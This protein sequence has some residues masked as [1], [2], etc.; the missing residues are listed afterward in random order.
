M[1]GQRH[2]IARL[3]SDL[4][5]DAFRKTLR[6]LVIS[7]FIMFALIAAIIYLIFFQPSVHYYANTI[8]GKIM[9]MPKPK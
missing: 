1:L 5:R 2:E 3:Q 4:Y 9:D 7:V 8:D 6:W